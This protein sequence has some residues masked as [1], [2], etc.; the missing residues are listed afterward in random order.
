MR[1]GMVL[2]LL[3]GF[4]LAQEVRVVEGWVRYP[5][6]L[7]VT[8]AYLTLENLGDAPLRLVGAEA[9][10]AE[11][12]ELH[13]TFHQEKDGKMV[14][15]MRPVDFAEVPPK[16]RL[17]LKPGGYHLMLFNLRRPL[18]LGERVELVLKFQNGTQLKV[19]LPVE[20]R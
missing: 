4:A 17:V 18:K 8:A 15:G 3:L 11:R 7:A 6:T 9:A 16:G 1:R 10:W 12:V 2:F 20:E 19:R 14:M 13:G 5:A